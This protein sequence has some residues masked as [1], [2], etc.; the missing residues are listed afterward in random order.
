LRIDDMHFARAADF[1]L[2][3][4]SRQRRGVR[5]ECCVLLA[6]LALSRLSG[7]RR[8]KLVEVAKH[9]EERAMEKWPSQFWRERKHE[10]LVWAKTKFQLIRSKFWSDLGW[11]VR[12]Q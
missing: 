7:A 6:D 10:K 11:Y 9:A 5:A 2:G 8:G 3:L 4:W 12:Y 1:A